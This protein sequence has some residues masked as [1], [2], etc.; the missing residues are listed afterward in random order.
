MYCKNQPVIL[1][2]ALLF[3]YCVLCV[4]MTEAS[5][6]GSSTPNSQRSSG[7]EESSV[8][9]SRNDSDE[10]SELLLSD[11]NDALHRIVSESE[12]DVR[13]DGDEQL[14]ESAPAAAPALT[15]SEPQITALRKLSL[16]IL[17]HKKAIRKA[18]TGSEHKRVR[19]HAA[20]TVKKQVA[21]TG[22]AVKK[23]VRKVVTGSSE[24]P[25]REWAKDVEV[26]K[27]ADKFSFVLGVTV[28]MGTEYCCLRHPEQFGLYY[29]IMVSLMMVLRFS[30]YARSRYLY[31][32]IDFCYMA[33]A[34]CFA[35]VLVYPENAQLWRLNFAVA[36]GTLLGA[37]LA[38][39]N[40]L[41]F[42]S[43]DKVTSIAIHLLPGLLTY[44]ER[45]SK[46][47]SVLNPANDTN[48]LVWK[49]SF[50][51]PLAFYLVWQLL[52]ILKTEI[53]DR[54]SLAAD[55]SIQ[56]SLRWLTRDTKNPMH[57]LAKRFCR[58]TGILGPHEHFSPE[59]LKTKLVFWSFN[60]LFIVFTLLPTP[61]LFYGQN[62]HTAYIL[63]VLATAVFNG[64][65]YYFEGECVG[66]SMHA[67]MTTAQSTLTV[68]QFLNLSLLS[69]SLCA[70]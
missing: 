26:V 52:Y 45:W 8:P 58:T 41:V 60:F 27:T 29:T 42:H 23:R 31:F 9:R 34:A 55:P 46:P 51:E 66:G 22:K 68:V 21:S 65:N 2:F 28:L 10:S 69:S 12:H 35:S 36:N 33:N 4:V 54:E 49:E 67:R 59:S 43:L 40:S 1:A 57:K 5:S 56:T 64:S 24:R 38:W 39:R 25:L 11:L 47:D 61:F 18:F 62:L 48:A 17:D 32:L 53:V 50:L 37:L 7:E 44:L 63:L 19:D 14:H 70:F 16:R 15:L 20:K 3:H 30:M 13:G 6:P